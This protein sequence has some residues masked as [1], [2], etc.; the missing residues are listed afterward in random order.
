MFDIAKS[1]SNVQ[2]SISLDIA[3]SN[4]VVLT[5]YRNKTRPFLIENIFVSMS[6]F[7]GRRVTKPLFTVEPAISV[8]GKLAD[9][10]GSKWLTR[11]SW[12]AIPNISFK[13]FPV[14]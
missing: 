8:R 1:G 7:D 5:T 2:G 10:G 11:Y 3:M 12:G 14:M 4:W 6:L 13:I 9:A